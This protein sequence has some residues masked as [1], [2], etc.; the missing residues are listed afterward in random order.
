MT[1]HKYSSE[2]GC[3]MKPHADG[4]RGG[5]V[6]KLVLAGALLSALPAAAEQAHH[7]TAPAAQ[8]DAAP[9]PPPPSDA[10]PAAPDQ[11][12]GMGSGMMGPA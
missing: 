3:T 10:S 8:T 9:A 2:G 1:T 7:T 5:A 12:G 11:Q 4:R 6:R